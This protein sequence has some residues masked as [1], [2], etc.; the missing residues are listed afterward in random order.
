[1]A[2]I[3]SQEN[4]FAKWLEIELSV[5]EAL[6]KR[7]EIPEKSFKNISENAGFDVQRIEE[8]EETVKH[9][10]IVFLT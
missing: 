5:C 10:V 3:W 1:M 8:I 2:S 9:D 6:A 7:G 4:R